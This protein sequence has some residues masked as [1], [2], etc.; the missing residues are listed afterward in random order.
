MFAIHHSRG[1]PSLT[2][3]L[4]SLQNFHARSPAI[5][6]LG[7]CLRTIRRFSLHLGAPPHSKSPGFLG[8][9]I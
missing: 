9:F 4:R 3:C 6:K 2:R 8:G 7:R 5:K 1:R